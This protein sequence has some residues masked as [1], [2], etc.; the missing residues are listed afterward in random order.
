[1]PMMIWNACFFIYSWYNI[2]G[3]RIC[4]ENYNLIFFLLFMGCTPHALFVLLASLHCLLRSSWTRSVV[5]RLPQPR[6]QTTPPNNAAA[7]MQHV[8]YW[9][10]QARQCSHM[11]H[12][13]TSVACNNKINSNPQ[14]PPHLWLSSEMWRSLVAVR[15]W[16]KLY[17]DQSSDFRS[18]SWPI[19]SWLSNIQA[20]GLSKAHEC[21]TRLLHSH[22]LC[23]PFDSGLV[24]E[25]RHSSSLSME[26]RLCCT[27]QPICVIG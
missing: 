20:H 5:T 7:H 25:R 8:S 4:L 15:P 18:G 16:K 9:S 26:L 19:C 12:W 23:H 24:Q 1:M 17:C 2:L 11:L 14:R 13:Y 27:N 3:A 21:I 22:P 10:Q 6:H